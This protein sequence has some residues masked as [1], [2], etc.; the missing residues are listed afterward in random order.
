M[1]IKRSLIFIVFLVIFPFFFVGL[2]SLFHVRKI[3]APLL[4]IASAPASFETLRSLEGPFRFLG[5]GRQSFAFV[6]ANDQWVLKFFNQN[7]FHLPLYASWSSEEKEKREKRKTYY[8]ESYLIA[9]K[10]LKEETGIIYLHLGKSKEELPTIELIDSLGFSHTVDLNTVPFVLQKKGTPLYAAIELKIRE[11]KFIEANA[12]IEQFF[13]LIR[14]RISQQIG[15]KDHDV[16]HNFGVANG[17]ILH[18]DPG[19][20][21]LDPNL[22]TEK[23]QDKQWWSSTHRFTQW[24]SI[25][26]DHEIIK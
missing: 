24:L 22:Q 2:S 1:R 3:K 20:L 18:L 13:S 15:D 4:P 19:R 11:Q 26:S 14:H 6:S 21:Y 10:F 23:A 9:E 8:K 17:K 16:E 25:F 7:Y 12:L 5:Q